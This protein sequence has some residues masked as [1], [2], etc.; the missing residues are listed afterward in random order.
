MYFVGL[1]L[2]WG[3]RKPTGVAVVD[4]TGK[5]VHLAVA[6]DDASIK[7]KVREEVRALTQRFPLYQ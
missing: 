4:D 5:L 1:D 6:Q 3:E 7:A 2:A